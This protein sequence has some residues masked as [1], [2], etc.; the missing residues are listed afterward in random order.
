MSETRPLQEWHS[1]WHSLERRISPYR[2]SRRQV[3]RG[4]AAGAAGLAALPLLRSARARA[5]VPGPVTPGMGAPDQ[6]GWNAGKPIKHVVVLCQE[7]RSFDH[8]Y[9]SFASE[10]GA[11]G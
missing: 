11:T 1:G 6:A 5:A 2:M 3:L 4:A 10:L 9:G 7:N 8:Y